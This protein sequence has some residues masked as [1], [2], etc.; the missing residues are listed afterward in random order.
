MFI[1]TKTLVRLVV[2]SVWAVG[3]GSL[4]AAQKGS[5]D[6]A[7]ESVSMKAP[8]SESAIPSKGFTT[9]NWYDEN[10]GVVSPSNFVYCFKATLIRSK[11]Y[12]VWAEDSEGNVLDVDAYPAESTSEEVAEPGASFAVVSG[13]WGTRSVLRADEWYIDE[14]DPEFS[15]PESWTYIFCIES[16]TPNVRGTFHFAQG[17]WVPLGIEENPLVLVPRERTEGDTTKAYSFVT[18]EFRFCC[19]AEFAYGRRYQFA[20]H[21]GTE[22]NPYS[23]AFGD[24]KVTPLATW[25]S[26]DNASFN[27]DPGRSGQGD[28]WI[29]EGSTNAEVV[30]DAKFSLTYRLVPVRT[31]A[32]HA[33]VR[34]E[35]LTVGESVECR[36]GRINATNGEYYDLIFDDC[37]LKAR[38]EKG[39]RYVLDTVGAQTNLFLFVYDMKGNVLH[40]C[41]GDGTD[42]GNAR[43]AFV[44]P[45]TSDCYV[46]LAEKLVDDERDEPTRAPVTLRFDS[47]EPQEGSPDSWD[48]AD[49]TYAG[50]VA[51]NPPIGEDPLTD[52]PEGQ[53]GWHRLGRTDWCDTFA[54]S[55]R[56]DCRYSLAVSLQDPNAFHGN[57]S[58]EVFMMDGRSKKRVATLGDINPGTLLPLTFDAEENGTYFI[59]LSVAEGQG[60]DY[61]AYRIHAVGYSLEHAASGVLKVAVY[62]TTAGMWS[63]NAEKTVYRAGTS[64]I[65]PQE[66]AYAVR[67][68]S[69]AGFLTPPIEEGVLVHD[70]AGR[71]VEGWYTDTFDPKDDRPSG[72]GVVG[73]KSVTYAATGLSLKN[74]PAEWSRTLWGDDAA[75]TFSFAGK[76][77]QYYDFDFTARGAVRGDEPDAVISIT[78]AELGVLC[79]NA[80]R[81]HQ[82]PLPTTKSKYILT[83]SHRV[84]YN[85]QNTFYTLSG[86]FANVGAIRFSAMEYK[87]KDNA[88]EVKLTVNRTA[89]DGK[90]RVRLTT[91]DGENATGIWPNTPVT[92]DPKIKFYHLDETLVWPNGDNKAKTVTVKLIPDR[93]PTFH[94]VVRA[95]AVKLEDA[96]D[97]TPDCYHAS[98]AVDSKTKKPLSEATVTLQESA[99]KTPGTIRVA[100]DGQDAKKPVYDVRAGETLAV[101]LVRS[102]GADADVEIRVDTSAVTG[103]SGT[104]ETVAW[105]KGETSAKTLSVPVTLA[106]GAKTFVKAALKL[107]ATSK[108]K[109]KFAAS[110]IT[111]NV[112]NDKFDMT[113]ADYA[114]ALP[115]TCGYTVKEGKAGTWTVTGG[116]FFNPAGSSA[117]TFAITGPA[118]FICKLD[119]VETSVTVTA[120]GKTETF[121]VPA[122]VKAVTD[123]VYVFNGGACE[124]VYQATQY[125]YGAP[126][127]DDASAKPK[128]AVGKLPDGI[129]LEQDKATKAWHVRGVPTKA[130]FYYAEIQDSAVKPAVS[131]T[132][133]AFEVVALRSAIGTF[134]GLAANLASAATT[135][136]LQ[137][138][139]QV[140]LT[141]A[142]NGK[143]SAKVTVGGKSH[144]LA[145][146]GF[147]R[148]EK[149]EDGVAELTARLTKEEKKTVKVDGKSVSVT[150]TNELVLTVRDLDEADANGWR[151]CADV[152]LT[153]D[154]LPDLK[155]SGFQTGVKYAGH[156]CR[157]NSKLSAWVTAAAQFAGYYTVALVPAG[158]KAG[159]P[160]GN[161]YLTLTLDEKGKVKVAGAL[162]NGTAYSASSVASLTFEE[163]D[164]GVA[165]PLYAFKS[166]TLFG[167]W[168]TLRF[169]GGA[170]D[171][172]V[173][174]PGDVRWIC[175]DAAA[176][177]DGDEFDLALTPVGGYYDTVASLQRYYLGNAFSIDSITGDDF[178]LLDAALKSNYGEGYAFVARTDNGAAVDGLA[179]DVLGD[180]VSVERQVLVK[181]TDGG[182]KTAFN[183]WSLS[184]NAANVKVSFKRATG[185]LTGT[186][187][188]WYEGMNG[189]SRVQNAIKGCKHAGVLLM[190]CDPASAA[191]L[192]EDVWT[193]GAVVIPQTI[194][195]GTKTRKWSA[196]YP[197]NVKAEKYGE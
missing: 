131:L 162:A 90:V 43:C 134:N 191:V 140:Q 108:D 30:A 83:V 185:V 45:Y 168:L 17:M 157:D 144:S 179:V 89:K 193:A 95:F 3:G 98:F 165:V 13:A 74:A 123:V 55:A 120:V 141:T 186:C 35:P 79:E 113:L 99:K 67:F 125:G 110:T 117:L 119:G 127:T 151:S 109:P 9:V 167:G 36:P 7:A 181:E 12:T 137:T 195:E 126:V 39:R 61:P 158:S 40:E 37:L 34:S 5:C 148:A 177:F 85:S 41:E 19:S 115:K 122:G 183:D 166:P 118:T 56:A 91:I 102:E 149:G 121:A 142:A 26:A 10:R 133:L 14:D 152:A 135:N 116:D 28:V 107:S 76:D 25:A 164:D 2:V 42:T 8:A 145:A 84:P 58:A 170:V 44:A 69:V 160:K 80:D 66:V 23:L 173:V 64:V 153:M 73:G 21:G 77:G 50:A 189:T 171:S 32:Q 96:Y 81:V 29:V 132:N 136:T 150:Y 176:T 197:F 49:D 82:L 124:T 11:A 53:E 192:G 87:A 154:C 92:D 46:G 71:T 48:A 18:N 104:F 72:R 78:N 147:E 63:L 38:L 188:F 172:A 129:K 105:A 59:A 22:K 196:T 139:A 187:D 70:R 100:D 27:Y 163:G 68:S 31:I 178:D 57:L 16:D 24:G 101:R 174:T 194:K 128:V 51:L 184:T 143:L 54:I 75:D 88:A 4:S 138:L 6:S 161:G 106:V 33:L 15:D 180:A 65:V 112:Y 169:K 93:V 182:R 130:G 20:T 155:G 103:K 52:D 97:G 94:E 86:F 1:K 60:R 47:A 114:K 62:G 111:V 159:E 146:N 175:Q 156:V 190:T